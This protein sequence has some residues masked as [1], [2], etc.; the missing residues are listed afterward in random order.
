VRESAKSATTGNRGST[1]GRGEGG[2]KAAGRKRISGQEGCQG[3]SERGTPEEGTREGGNV[4]MGG[5][6]KGKFRVIVLGVDSVL[7]R[8]KIRHAAANER[9]KNLRSSYLRG[10]FE[11]CVPEARGRGGQGIFQRLGEQ[12]KPP[13]TAISALRKVNGGDR[14]RSRS[15]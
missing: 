12:R 10:C 11:G 4:E 9:S 7:G 15:D 5:G 6:E 1:E 2:W 14:E 8:T 3:A 13:E